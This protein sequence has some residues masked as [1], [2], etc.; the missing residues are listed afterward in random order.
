[1]TTS[2]VTPYRS[3]QQAGRDGFAQ[4]LRAEWT[5]FRTVRGWAI[6]MVV[7]ALVTV[8]LGLFTASRSECSVGPFPGQPVAQPCRAALGPGGEAVTD[9]FYFVHQPLA[10][11]GSITVR[12]TALTGMIP[13]MHVGGQ[14]TPGLQPWSKAGI[15]IKQGTEQGSAYAAMMVTGGHGV[16]MQYDFT[17]DSAGLAGA[18]SAASPRWLRLTRTGNT[19]TGYESADGTHWTRV[20]TARLA[21]LPSTVQAGLFAASP[22]YT[23]VVS[24]SIGSST[25][26]GGPTQA[27]AALDHVSLQG[28][29]PS[30]AWT[31]TA[32]GAPLGPVPSAG[33]G[34]FHRAGGAFTVS[35][36]GD[37]A[38]SVRDATPME[39]TLIGAFAGLIAVIVVATMFITAEY[40]RGLIRT[41]LAASPRR[42]RVLAA[43]AIVI[44]V[45][46]FVAGLAAAAVVV[47]LGERILRH[48]GNFI[49]PAPMLTEV[50]V[51][52]GTAALLAVAAVLALAVGAVLR[53]SAG[54]VTAVIAG[55]VLAYILATA[56]VLPVGPSEWLLRLTPAAA[57]AIQQ[58]TPQYP[59][60]AASY[61]PVNGYFPLAPWAGLAVLCGYAALALGLAVVLLRRRDV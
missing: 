48:N 38:P 58:S 10:G 57:F 40:R 46:T 60:V 45:V 5:K 2:T 22:D 53:R 20:G 15:I 56:A 61:T 50:R 19:I 35:G 11:N 17:H 49:A 25:T 41:T 42:G 59:Q 43:K 27:T 26:R 4:L 18:V 24:Q 44:G 14:A 29:W 39:R 23:Q 31:G 52:A 6:G 21:G 16:R 9:S 55:I 54:A 28:Q 37:I 12:V 36:S 3:S 51:V 7:A 33:S 47:P 13:S 1:M 8:G 34:G 30:G 32:V